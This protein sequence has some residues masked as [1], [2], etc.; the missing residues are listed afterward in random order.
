MKTNTSEKYIETKDE[1]GKDYLC[2]ISEEQGD[3]NTSGIS[4]DEC[5]EKDVL[6]RYAGNIE[7][8]DK[9]T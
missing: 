2:P 9:E 5:F 1:S 3:G 7:I 4:E 6:Q 8:A